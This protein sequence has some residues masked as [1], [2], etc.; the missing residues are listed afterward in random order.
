MIDI[1]KIED[2]W[3][4][5][6]ETN[7]KAALGLKTIVGHEPK[8]DDMTLAT[9]MPLTPFVLLRSG[10]LTPEQSEREASGKSGVKKSEFSIVFGHSSLRSSKDARHGCYDIMAAFMVRYDGGV[11]TVPG[12]G[13]INL[14]FEDQVFLDSEGGVVSYMQIYSYYDN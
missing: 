11:I 14:Q 5:D 6:I 7:L 4:V 2:A 9:L 1:G 8:Y 10:R 12:E 13:Q 3:I